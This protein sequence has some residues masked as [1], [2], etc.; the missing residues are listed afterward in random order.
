[1]AVKETQ[2][3]EIKKDV[4]Y[5]YIHKPE[6]LEAVSKLITERQYKNVSLMEKLDKEKYIA[7]NKNTFIFRVKNFFGVK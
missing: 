2:L 7:E 1:M 6:F 5:P 3:L 4:M